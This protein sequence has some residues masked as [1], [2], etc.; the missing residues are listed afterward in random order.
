M[1]FSHRQHVYP[2]PFP[3]ITLMRRK[4]LIQFRGMSEA[5][6]HVQSEKG[7]ILKKVFFFSLSVVAPSSFPMEEF[8]LSWS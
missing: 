5:L 7:K 8:S 2:F 4:D 1:L 3:I 6:H